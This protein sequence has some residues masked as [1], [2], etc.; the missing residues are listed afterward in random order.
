MNLDMLNNEQR[1]A[2]T[3]IDGPLL[4]VAGAGSGK[5]RVL[6]SRIAYMIEKGISPFN[7]LAITFTNKAAKEMRDR[8][9]GLVGDAALTMQIS[10]F[11]SFG[12][13]VIRENYKE[14][15]LENNFTIFD[16]EDSLAII[17]RIL[18]NMNVDTKQFPPK[19]FKNSISSLKNELMDWEGF[20]KYIKNDYD[21]LLQEVY[22]RYS[23]ELLDNNG[24]DFD[25]LLVMPIILFRKNKDILEHYQDKFKYILIDE[26]QDTNEA[27]Y[28]L[29]KMISKKYQNICVV[30]D[31]DQTI[32]GFRGA[33]FKNI[34]NFEKDYPTCST[35]VLDKNYRSTKNILDVANSVIKNNVNRY[36]KDLISVLGDGD[37]V[38]YY[39]ARN[40]LDEINY[41][42]N[43]INGIVKNNVSYDDIVILYRTNAQSRAFEEALLKHNIPYRI[44]GSVNF[45]SRKEIKDLIAY[46]KLINNPRDSIS[47]LRAINTP[48]RGIGQKTIE[49]LTKKAE[50]N[51]TSLFDV[52]ESGKALEFKKLINELIDASSD[53][54]LTELVDLVLEKSGL[55]KELEDEKSLEADLRLDNLEEFKSITKAFEEK[56]GVISLSDFLYEVGLISDNTEITDTSNRVT[57]MTVH[58]VK[59]LEFDYVF[60]TGLEENL[61]PH[62]NCLNDESEIEEERR[63]CYVAITRARKK[64]YLTNACMRVL[65]GMDQVNGVSRFINEINKDDLDI[66]SSNERE[67]YREKT[68]N[69]LKKVVKV[70]NSNWTKEVVD[71]YQVGDFVY[72]DNFGT[73]KVL[74][75]T[76][77]IVKVAFKMP[78]GVKTLM[79]NHK[80]LRK[81]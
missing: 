64:L 19:N 58:A 81:V 80:S 35:I 62:S 51:E 40:G 29:T 4:V 76:D 46:L 42:I 48:K 17:K 36:D 53:L 54:S 18:K 68:N 56:Y 66:V 27:Q 5:T 8:V 33:N 43:E 44:I 21:R 28:V 49:D 72:H 47:L 1:K 52:I 30:G 10:T 73:G 15:G 7:I 38:T 50:G 67:A 75:V 3:L 2:V 22:K 9:I 25:D 31:S 14:L 45:Y 37:K 77:T 59:G 16:S 61:F 55:K 13:R 24:V 12:L 69:N 23:K 70:V 78:Y 63:L 26:Y 32:Y 79:K 20:N 34:L 71:D 65:Y 74:I 11:H 41:I 39:R 60:V 6:T 57:L